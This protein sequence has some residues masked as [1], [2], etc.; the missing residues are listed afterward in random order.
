MLQERSWAPD[1]LQALQALELG[2][3]GRPSDRDWLSTVW[4]QEDAQG[5]F[6]GSSF[7]CLAHS[8]SSPHSCPTALLPPH[9]SL[10]K[11]EVVSPCSVFCPLPDYR[12]SPHPLVDPTQC[13]PGPFPQAGQPGGLRGGRPRLEVAW[14]HLL[15]FPG[16]WGREFAQVG[17]PP[18]E[19]LL[20]SQ[21][22]P[23]HLLALAVILVCICWDNPRGGLCQ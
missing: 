21:V 7:C 13:P 6:L 5:M 17:L 18:K 4:G 15:S 10:L 11:W 19:S 8:F 16:S 1:F 22:L 2:V 20:G 12:F 3:G 9:S 23:G 14:P